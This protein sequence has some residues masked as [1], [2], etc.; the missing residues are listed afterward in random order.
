[1]HRVPRFRREERLHHQ[2]PVDGRC[3]RT[4]NGAHR[5][6]RP[7]ARLRDGDGAPLL[8]RV[9]LPSQGDYRIV[10]RAFFNSSERKRL[11]KEAKSFMKLRAARNRYVQDARKIPVSQPRAIEPTMQEEV[12]E[13]GSE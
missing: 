7:A 5:V 4:S 10:K 3:R 9:L 6:S 12:V 1:R 8:R 11:Y 2:Q 13:V